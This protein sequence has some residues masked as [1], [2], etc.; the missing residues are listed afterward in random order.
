MRVIIVDDEPPARREMR[1]LLLECTWMEVVGE[2]DGAAE[3]E[4]LIEDL[5]PDLIFL[6]IEMPGASG[7][8]LLSRLEYVP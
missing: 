7:F 3:A 6:D 2:A 4:A 1:R 8:D 5:Q